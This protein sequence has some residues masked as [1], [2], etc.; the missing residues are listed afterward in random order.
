MLSGHG[1]PTLHRL[2][3]QIV[4]DD[5]GGAQLSE[6]FFQ[7]LIAIKSA[8]GHHENVR[9]DH[10]CGITQAFQD[11]LLHT[12]ATGVVRFGT[13][14]SVDQPP[15]AQMGEERGE[16]KSIVV[17]SASAFLLRVGVVE[18]ADVHVK[19]HRVIFLL[20]SGYLNEL[21][22]NFGLFPQ[23]DRALRQLGIKTSFL[24]ESQEPLSQDLGGRNTPKAK[25]SRKEIITVIFADMIE[26]RFALTHEADQRSENFA[27]LD[28]QSFSRPKTVDQCIQTTKP[29]YLSDQSQANITNVIQFVSLGIGNENR[30]LPCH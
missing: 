12:L 14:L 3:G 18:N 9:I 13:K 17:R 27:L 24:G 19:T 1:E 21:R 20:V 30:K 28:L 10:G 15:T 16:A 7:L 29:G 4:L 5:E 23:F 6:Q 2:P 8:V 11:E 26:I 25:A 22:L